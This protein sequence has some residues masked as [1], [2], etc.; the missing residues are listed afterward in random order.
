[1]FRGVSNPRTQTV[2][3]EEFQRLPGTIISGPGAVTSSNSNAQLSMGTTQTQPSQ[4]QQL[5]GSNQPFLAP[6]PVS[7]TPAAQQP[8]AIQPAAI[9]PTNYSWVPA[10]PN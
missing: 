3:Y 10:S 5:S 1:M 8:A 7:A 6:P 9:Q 2:S 4:I